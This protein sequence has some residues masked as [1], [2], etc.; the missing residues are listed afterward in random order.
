MVLAPPLPDLFARL[1]DPPNGTTRDGTPGFVAGWGAAI[2]RLLE[3]WTLEPDWDDNG[4][5]AP[6][7]AALSGAIVFAEQQKKRWENPLSDGYGPLPP[8]P[9][10]HRIAP[11][12]DGTVVLEWQTPTTYLEIEVLSANAADGM[13]VA[14]GAAP[15]HTCLT[16]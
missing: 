9:P 12:C 1:S 6:D 15:I 5:P 13:L 2:D 16:W 3:L 11:S 8:F 4:S 10:P 7:R 14:E